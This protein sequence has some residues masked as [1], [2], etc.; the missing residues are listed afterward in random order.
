LLLFAQRRDDA[1][2]M[3]DV[4]SKAPAKLTALL[5]KETELQSLATQLRSGLRQDY[6]KRRA[7][8]SSRRSNEINSEVSRIEQ[9]LPFERDRAARGEEAAQRQE[10][11]TA[12]QEQSLQLCRVGG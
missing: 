1:L 3:G 8:R 4:A 7:A 10:R 12:V 2:R 9:S 11:L 6:A 5:A